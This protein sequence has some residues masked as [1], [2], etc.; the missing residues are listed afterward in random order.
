MSKT[1]MIVDDK[2]DTVNMVEALLSSKGYDVISANSGKEALNKL[3]EIEN[4]PDLVL[5]DMFMPEMSGREVCEK[6]RNTEDIKD[7]KIVFFTVASFSDKGKQ[8]LKELNV[9]DYITKPFDNRDLL[10]R[11][12]KIIGE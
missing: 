7:L 3:N 1:I 8:M 6:I 4:K 11:I 10:E 12:K 2:I 9:S 5:L